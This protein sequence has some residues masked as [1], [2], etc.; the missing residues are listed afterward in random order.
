MKRH[1]VVNA[2]IIL[3][4]FWIICMVSVV[5]WHGSQSTQPSDSIVLIKSEFT[6]ASGIIVDESGI[7][8]TAGHVLD[9]PFFGN[10]TPKVILR[11]GATYE[12]T[13]IFVAEDVDLGIC[14]I[15]DPNNGVFPV[16]KLGD[17][18]RAV[19]GTEVTA[20][21]QPLG[22]GW[23]NS[24][25]HIAKN[26]KCDTIYLDIA[27]NPGSSGCAVFNDDD[28]VIGVVI[29][30]YRNADGMIM[31]HPANLAKPLIDYYKRLYGLKCPTH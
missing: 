6:I 21:G 14:T 29:A 3:V 28:E 15:V 7:I 26:S 9:S 12:I 25:G 8:L 17:S 16:A 20:I 22:K 13:N 2:V 4:T 10:D 11:N 5:G 24:Y 27:C 19:V 18:C 23:W 30:G 1:I 31:C